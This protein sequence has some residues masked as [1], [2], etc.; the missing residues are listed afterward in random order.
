MR[1]SDHWFTESEITRISY[2]HSWY[3][4]LQVAI[5]PSKLACPEVLMSRVMQLLSTPRVWMMGFAIAAME[6]MNGELSSEQHGRRIMRLGPG[7]INPQIQVYKGHLLNFRY[8]NNS[9][10]ATEWQMSYCG[11]I[12]IDWWLLLPHRLFCKKSPWSHAQ[13]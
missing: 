4:A 10:G 13:I 1:R 11:I 9:M 5:R 6:A 12:G 8:F 7:E 2:W 3:A